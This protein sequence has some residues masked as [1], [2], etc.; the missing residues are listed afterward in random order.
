MIYIQIAAY[1]DPELV[2]TIQDCLEKAKW[3]DALRFGICWQREEGDQCLA[4]FQS[5]PRFRIDAVPWQGSKGLCWARARIQGMYEGEDYTLQLDSHH[6]FAQDWDEQLLRFMEL[7]GSQKP[8]LT[9]YAGMYSPKTNRKQNEDPYKMVADRFTPGGTILFRPNSIQ[10]WRDLNKP[11]RAR[12]VSGHFFFTL[13]SHCTEYKYDPHLYFAGDEISLAIRS[14]TLGYDLFHP[15]RTLIWHEYTR[16]GRVK[17]WTDHT[18]EN[19]P[20]VGL[21]WHERDVISK[22]RL[23]KMLREED[24]EEDVTGYDLGTVRTHREYELYAG[25]DFARRRLHKETVQ[26][27]E[28]PSTYVNDAQWEESFVSEHKVTLQWDTAQIEKC[29]DY[30]FI[31]FGVEDDLGN[32]LFRHD[33]TPESPEATLSIAKK[34]VS[35][36]S[37]YKPSKLVVWPVSKSRGWLKRVDYAL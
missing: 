5:D 15:H 17:H 32:V 2:P 36:R 12:F 6:R 30:Q 14:Y 13:G 10:G 23:R 11:V 35:I 31:Y 8:I 3:K 37:A 28:P 18:M 4:P 19:K 33:A 24:N 9:A 1:K 29:D 20:V 7:T 22:R 27:A 26:G 16:E 21:A 34:V 25:I